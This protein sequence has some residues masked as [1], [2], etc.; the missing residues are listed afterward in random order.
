MLLAGCSDDTPADPGGG[1]LPEL[2][3][4]NGRL[5]FTGTMTFAGRERRLI[6]SLPMGYN[7]ERRVPL[8]LAYHGSG[9]GAELMRDATGL[10]WVADDHGFAVIYPEASDRFFPIPCPGCDNDGRG[11]FEEINFAR[12]IIRWASENYAIHPDSAYA[13]GFSMG[14]FFINYLG[15]VANSP[16][17]GIAPVAAGVDGLVASVHLNSG[18][19]EYGEWTLGQIDRLIDE[20]DPMIT[21]AASWSLRQMI[22]HQASDV[23][24]Y[25]ASRADRMAALPRREVRNKLNTGRKSGRVG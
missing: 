12:E 10:G 11:G 2:P 23:E 4:W 5:E 8:L 3:E 21:K 24:T 20:R 1:E 17:R 7:H 9:M 15:C 16:V 6:G 18:G 22:K 14:G 13:T 25:V 19:T